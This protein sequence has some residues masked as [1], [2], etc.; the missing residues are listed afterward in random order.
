MHRF[1]TVLA[2]LL[3][4]LAVGLFASANEHGA[5]TEDLAVAALLACLAWASWK[6]R[7]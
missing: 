1:W 6:A 2:L 4:A 7:R 5:S 3:A